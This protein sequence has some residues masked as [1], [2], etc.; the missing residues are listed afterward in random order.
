[1]S[2]TF[3]EAMAALEADASKSAKL[4]FP[5]NFREP[6]LGL[7]KLYMREKQFGEGCVCRDSGS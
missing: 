6:K 3:A 7:A 1:M 2:P 4:A 5:E